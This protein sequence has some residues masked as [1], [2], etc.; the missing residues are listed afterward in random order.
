[1]NVL[2]SRPAQRV[3]LLGMDGNSR[4]VTD[5]RIGVSSLRTREAFRP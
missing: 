2:C 4:G 1:M 3:A 5:R